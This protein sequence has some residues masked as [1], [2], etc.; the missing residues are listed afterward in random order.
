[1]FS[2]LICCGLDRQR[3]RKLWSCLLATKSLKTVFQRKR[4]QRL[5]REKSRGSKALRICILAQSCPLPSLLATPN[6]PSPL[7]PSFTHLGN[8]GPCQKPFLF[9]GIRPTG[10]L[11]SGPALTWRL[12]FPCGAPLCRGRNGR[13]NKKH[14]RKELSGRVGG[15]DVWAISVKR[16]LRQEWPA[17]WWDTV[18][19]A[20]SAAE[21][22][23]V[24][25]LRSLPC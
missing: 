24:I 18:T 20:C 22:I 19:L 23:A 10:L 12:L 17:R 4:G 25:Y 3:V 11:C 6:A 16:L 2:A 14:P 15:R 5:R 21:F 13:K 9:P 8:R 1:M 7:P